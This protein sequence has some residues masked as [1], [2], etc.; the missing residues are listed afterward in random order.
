MHEGDGIHPAGN[1]TETH[2]P[3]ILASDAN[4]DGGGEAFA[5]H[6]M[7]IPND[8]GDGFTDYAPEAPGEPEDDFVDDAP[9]ASDES[10]DGFVDYAPEQAQTTPPVAPV[11]GGGGIQGASAPM[12]S[13]SPVTAPAPSG[14]PQRMPGQFPA[15]MGAQGRPQQ[16]PNL[17][18]F[19]S[20]VGKTASAVAQ[21]TGEAVNQARQT[22]N[23][24]ATFQ[25]ASAQV[26]AVSDKQVPLGK[27]IAV[28]GVVVALL[29]L[30]GTCSGNGN[31]TAPGGGA[32]MVSQN[33]PTTPAY[34]TLEGYFQLHPEEWA[35]VQQNAS[36]LN[37]SGLYTITCSVSGNTL[38]YNQTV[39]GVTGP[40]SIGE[41]VMYGLMGSMQAEDIQNTM[42]SVASDLK[43]TTGLKGIICEFN[44]YGS[45]GA[46]ITNVVGTA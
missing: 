2:E 13:P 37:I 20:N 19:A 29:L 26:K 9:E 17:S 1:P 10:G 38:S 6:A 33:V 45:D 41:R 30:L 34:T 24:N 39:Q 42:N 12:A 36:S 14:V 27:V 18:D 23:D 11:M 43:Q 3:V 22:L 5:E 8:S 28:V 4:G 25:N 32:G 7:E 15:G 46:L 40:E 44:Q 16:T 35:R 31:S 21:G